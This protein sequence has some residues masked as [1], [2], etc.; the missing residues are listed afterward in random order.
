M[1]KKLYIFLTFA[2]CGIGGT[3]IYLRNKIKYLHNKGWKTCVVTTEP[4]DNIIIKELAPYKHGIFK[5]LANNPYIYSRLKRKRLL[6]NIINYIHQFEGNPDEII[7]ESN[8]IGISPWGEILA[9]RLIAKHFILFIQEDYRFRVVSYLK[10][11]SFK[12]NRG[13]LAVN[14][15][16]AIKTLFEGYKEITNEIDYKLNPCCT[17]SIEDC[18]SKIQENLPDADFYIGSFGRINKPFVLPM[19]DQLVEYVQ[20]HSNKTFHLVLI[21]WTNNPKDI[22]YINEKIKTV[23]N[24]SYQITGPIYPVPR[25]DIKKMNVF[26][27][28]SGAASAT[29]N[30][31]ILTI[32][33]DDVDLKP[34]GILGYTTFKSLH[35]D[36][37]PIIELKY[38][39]DDILFEKKY[40]PE[41][42]NATSL[43][44][45]FEKKFDEHMEFINKS[46]L[47]IKYYPIVKLKPKFISKLY[48]WIRTTF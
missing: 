10:F 39:L 35:R 26:I 6:K 18:E 3:Q 40:Q 9:E 13:E 8:Y 36:K 19:I 15:E 42:K 27:S 22:Q 1:N 21:G 37:E 34:I 48:F 17:N 46:D 45:L 28:T 16:R 20:L 25:C 14:S 44:K 7:I 5:E 32:S 4:G 31:G 2:V 30:E 11:L 33:M 23:D 47:T 29:Y 43:E 38:L 41:E 12:L 24:L